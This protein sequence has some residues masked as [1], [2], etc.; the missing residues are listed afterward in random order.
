MEG[1]LNLRAI[2]VYPVDGVRFIQ[3]RLFCTLL[4]THGSHCVEIF[5]E[6]DQARDELGWAEY[7]RIMEDDDEVLD[8]SFLVVSPELHCLIIEGVAADTIVLPPQKAIELF[9]M[10]ADFILTD[11]EDDGLDIEGGR[12]GWRCAFLAEDFDFD[13][14]VMSLGLNGSDFIDP[15]C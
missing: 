15:Y 10:Y 8:R 6:T 2:A 3:S 7:D 1:E 14:F 4:A 12:L 13:Q 9:P 11:S 5:L